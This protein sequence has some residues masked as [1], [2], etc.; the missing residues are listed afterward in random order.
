MHPGGTVPPFKM[1]PGGTVPPVKMH[2]GGTV[3]PFKMHPGGTLNFHELFFLSLNLDLEAKINDRLVRLFLSLSPLSFI[4]LPPP[5]F[6]VGCDQM[7]AS[8]L[9]LEEQSLHLCWS[10][11]LIKYDQKK[12]LLFTQLMREG[13]QIQVVKL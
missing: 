9:T 12:T 6:Q 7:C 11:P 5:P 2:P 3:P 4:S 1:H 8:M 13:I 10:H